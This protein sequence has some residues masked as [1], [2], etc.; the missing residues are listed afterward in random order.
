MLFL[1][2]TGKTRISPPILGRMM[3]RPY[4]GFPGSRMDEPC[5]HPGF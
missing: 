4:K 2:D 1:Q 3:I 5:V